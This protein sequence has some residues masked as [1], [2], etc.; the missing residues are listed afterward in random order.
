VKVRFQADADLN[1]IT[2]RGVLR[3]QPDVD[4]QSADAVPLVAV[5]DDQVLALAAD[6]NR[7]LVTHDHSTMPRHFAA[8]VERQTSPGIIVVP[9]KLPV[10]VVVEELLLIWHASEA[11]EWINIVAYLPL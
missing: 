10:R 6:D 11:E 1:T 7:I 3:R 9:Q 8:F 5:P 4:F 2:V